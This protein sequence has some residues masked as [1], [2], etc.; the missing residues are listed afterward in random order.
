MSAVDVSGAIGSLCQQVGQRRLPG[1]ISHDPVLFMRAVHA[2]LSRSELAAAICGDKTSLGTKQTTEAQYFDAFYDF[3]VKKPDLAV[4]RVFG[5]WCRKRSA[6]RN[7]CALHN[8]SGK[9][10]VMG[11]WSEDLAG[12]GALGPLM[13]D[14]GFGAVLLRH[15]HGAT[16]LLHW[17]QPAPPSEDEAAGQVPPSLVW[18]CTSDPILTS[19]LIQTWWPLAKDAV[20]LRNGDGDEHPQTQIE[21]ERLRAFAWRLGGRPD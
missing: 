1:V 20:L 17:N 19:V 9:D 7:T 8:E 3:A 6:A 21:S 16:V 14:H 15:S 11:L 10:R 12:A 4:V 5:P 18:T 13:L 2:L